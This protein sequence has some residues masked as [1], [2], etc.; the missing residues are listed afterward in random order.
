MAGDDSILMSRCLV[1]VR[2]FLAE[3]IPEGNE[4]LLLI[5][6]SGAVLLPE[7]GLLLVLR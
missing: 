1:D 7:G 4:I 6:L 3:L 5:A 2:Q